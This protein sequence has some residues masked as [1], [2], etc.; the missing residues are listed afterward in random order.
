MKLAVIWSRVVNWSRLMN[1]SWVINWGWFVNWSM[2]YW[3]VYRGWVKWSWLMNWSWSCVTFIRYICDVASIVIS[4]VF[5]ILASTIGKEYAVSTV[6]D[7]VSILIF[8]SLKVCTS[9]FITYAISVMVG[10]RFFIFRLVIF[11]LMV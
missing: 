10:F 6:D 9:V 3:L 1:W 8:S 2:I 4:C 11:R 7:T 5:Y